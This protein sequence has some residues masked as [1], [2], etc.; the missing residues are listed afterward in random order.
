MRGTLDHLR[1][2]SCATNATAPTTPSR[3]V[4]SKAPAG[5]DL[6]HRS[7]KA[8]IQSPSSAR[9][10]PFILACNLFVPSTVEAS[11]PLYAQRI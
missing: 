3:K 7:K 11:G 5:D 6:R 8:V 4:L 9:T 2:R 1:S 10:S